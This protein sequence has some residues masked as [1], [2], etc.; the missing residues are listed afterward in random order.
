MKRV[1]LELSVMEASY[2]ASL[3]RHAETKLRM[4]VDAIPDEARE[5]DWVTDWINRRQAQ[6]FACARLKKRTDDLIREAQK[7]G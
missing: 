4:D 7:R 6:L 5:Q 3:L 1:T 2:L